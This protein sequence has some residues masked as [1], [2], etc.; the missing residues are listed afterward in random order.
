LREKAENEYSDK[1][2]SGYPMN[3]SEIIELE[4]VR[5]R[6]HEKHMSYIYGLRFAGLALASTTIII[7][8]VMTFAGLTGSFNWAFRAPKEIGAKLTNASPG[9]VFATVGMAIG[10][11]VVAQRPV[12]YSTSGAKISADITN[13]NGIFLADG[14][15]RKSSR[16][17]IG[18]SED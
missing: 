15:I 4:I 13:R 9:I 5:L 2:W 17:L 7:G 16:I 12:N 18:D 1:T 10:L 11:L 14:E 3:R 6:S 8:A